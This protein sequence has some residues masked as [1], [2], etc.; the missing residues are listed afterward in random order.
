MSDYDETLHRAQSLPPDERLKLIG[1]LWA[2]LPREYWPAATADELADANRLTAKQQIARG[3]EVPWAVVEQMLA[4][5]VRSSRPKVYSTPRR[6]DLA[7]M[8]VVTTAYALLFAAMA[9]LQFPPMASIL[10]AA[11]ITLVGI[12]Q[13]ILFGGLRPRTA[14]IVV[15]TA[16]ICVLMGGSLIFAG[17]MYFFALVSG[18]I[19][20]PVLGYIAGVMVGGV[21][22][23]ADKL[24]QFF[25]RRR[26]PAEVA[27]DNTVVTS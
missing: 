6:F 5:C 22:L 13:S 8:F 17:R 23:V 20:G 21:F 2:S 25:H 26:A 10:T 18:I 24:R 19:Y 11:F 27:D 1:R 9:A 15:G 12:G 3:D 4:D 14:S 7:T 16:S